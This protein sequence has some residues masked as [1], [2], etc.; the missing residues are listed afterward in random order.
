MSQKG[1]PSTAHEYDQRD[2]CIHCQM[3]RV[4]VEAMSHDCTV[5]REE[6]VDRMIQGGVPLL[7]QPQAQ[8]GY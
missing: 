4:N 5:A 8:S 2:Q 1:K 7:T 6:K 3:Y